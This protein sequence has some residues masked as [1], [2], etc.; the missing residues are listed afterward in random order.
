MT[1]AGAT[2]WS[3]YRPRSARVLGLRT[4]PDTLPG[5]TETVEFWPFSQGEIEGLPDGFVDA[6]FTDPGALNQTGG[7]S[8]GESAARI[9]RGG[10]PE[11][12]GR[13][14]PARRQRPKSV[15]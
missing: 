9:V 5:R 8:R 2:R 3:G 15:H 4:L 1:E 10:I 11:A 13:A 14:N 7:L 6:A 12:V